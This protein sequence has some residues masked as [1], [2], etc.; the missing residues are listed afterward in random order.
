MKKNI[1]VTGANGFIGS[2]F[3]KNSG[4][5]NTE[6]VS[7][8]NTQISDINFEKTDCIIHFAALAHQ[9]NKVN[10]KEYFSINR[11]LTIEL[12]KAA[13]K[14]SV[15]HFIFISSIKVYGESTTGEMPWNE[16]SQCK[17]L[18]AYG[19]SKL[20]AEN[21]LK[22]MQDDDFNV[23]IVRIPLVYGENVKGN[24]QRIIKLTDKMKILPLGGIKNKRSL[25]YLENLII[26]LKEIINLKVSG[27]F[28]LCDDDTLSTTELTKYIATALKKKII[29]IKIP[30][31]LVKFLAIFKP[32]IID[33]LFG[34]LELN[35]EKTNDIL[36]NTNKYSSEYGVNQMVE[37]Y[38][39]NK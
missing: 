14:K 20:E 1:I 7:L 19:R 2:S 37:Y 3:I 27:T 34:S 31:F 9:M 11:D 23:S 6:A 39:N 8:R 35:C 26:A 4:E 29:L 28:L 21:E 25:I 5:Y 13:K 30:G 18:D 10:D 36:K 22:K 38:K 17:P 15:N 16:N 32:S 24:L 33:R 12:A